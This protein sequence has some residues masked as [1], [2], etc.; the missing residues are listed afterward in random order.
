MAWQHVLKKVS[1][2]SLA[3]VCG[4]QILLLLI[5]LHQSINLKSKLKK[6]IKSIIRFG[7]KKE[8]RDFFLF[9]LGQIAQ[10]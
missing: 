1:V 8:I 5:N 2:W 10:P 4:N 3:K 6:Y 7:L 9:F